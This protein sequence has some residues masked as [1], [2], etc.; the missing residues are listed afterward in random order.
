[1]TKTLI[2]PKPRKGIELSS[3]LG[4]LQHILPE[5]EAMKNVPQPAEFHPEGDVWDHTML[6]LDYLPASPEIELSMAVLLHDVGKPLTFKEEDRIR[7]NG[8]VEVGA[9][10]AD[11]IMRRLRFSKN[12]QDMVVDLVRQHHKF[13]EV[14]NMRQSTLKRFLRSERFDL[15]LDLHRIDCKASH[16][17]LENWEFCRARIEEF[18]AQNENALRPPSLL[19]GHDLIEMGLSPGPE[20]GRILKELEDAQLDG[21]VTTREEA[22]ALVRRTAGLK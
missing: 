13:M 2:G 14:Q 16:R 21:S 19:T 5:I 11:K 15:H 1:M 7:F 18:Q 17:N 20:F 8:H 22:I 6:A 3:N 9:E 4:L 10:I 12:Q